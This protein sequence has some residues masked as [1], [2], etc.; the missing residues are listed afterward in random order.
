MKKITDDELKDLQ[1]RAK[2]SLICVFT[3]IIILIITAI[4]I[5]S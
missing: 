5:K 4:I 3:L 1:R 2:L